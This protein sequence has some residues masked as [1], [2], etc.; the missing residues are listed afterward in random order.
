MCDKNFFNKV[1]LHKMEFNYDWK[2]DTLTRMSE[3]INDREFS[4]TVYLALLD[5]KK[6]I[7]FLIILINMLEN[8]KAIQK[9]VIIKKI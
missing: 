5:L 2:S 3:K 7:F 6:M 9:V 1:I 8:I 4:A